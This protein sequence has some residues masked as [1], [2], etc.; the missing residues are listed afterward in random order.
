MFFGKPDAA[1]GACAVLNS[2][3]FYAYFIAYGDCFHLSDGLATGFPVNDVIMTDKALVE[4]NKKLMKDLRDQAVRKTINTKDGDEITYEEFYGGRSKPIIDD[5]DC[6]LANH[7]G[8]TPDELDFILNY[9]IKYR[10]GG[11]DAD[12]VGEGT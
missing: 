9:D 4:L 1:H 5:I 6:V 10:I 3:L 7:Y 11:G 2:S 8:F 12:D